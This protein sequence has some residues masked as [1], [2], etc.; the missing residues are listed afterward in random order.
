MAQGSLK[1]IKIDKN[2]TT[3]SVQPKLFGYSQKYQSRKFNE[4][5]K[6]WA[7]LAQKPT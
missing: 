7:P 4:A 6:F 2:S 3:T 1:L 5:L